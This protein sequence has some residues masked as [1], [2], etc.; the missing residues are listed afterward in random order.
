MHDKSIHGED[1]RVRSRWVAKEYNTGA[2][3][4]Q[5]AGTAPLAGVNLVLSGAAS[6]VGST[7]A[8]IGI[9][10]VSRAFFCAK[11]SRAVFVTL[12]AEDWQPGTINDAGGYASPCGPVTQQPIGH[13]SWATPS[14]AWRSSPAEET[15]ACIGLI[16]GR[17]CRP[18]IAT[19]WRWRGPGNK[20]R[21]SSESSQRPRSSR[22]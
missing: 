21:R 4:D 7:D 17:S 10:D 20:S 8:C 16:G 14:I 5:Y 12:P 15:H 19:T 1:T 13:E 18:C 2:M 22:G 11:A 9:V 6:C 3:P